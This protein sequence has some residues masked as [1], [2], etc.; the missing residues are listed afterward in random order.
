MS[1]WRRVAWS[2]GASAVT[3]PAMRRRPI[4][5][6][7]AQPVNGSAIAA[8]FG[9]AAAGLAHAGLD[10]RPDT[11]RGVLHVAA[12]GLQ[13]AVESARGGLRLLLGERLHHGH[14][15]EPG[16]ESQHARLVLEGAE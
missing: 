5:S 2:S 6:T 7:M 15:V 16:E 3:Y 10:D 1:T 13:G 12:C 8:A 14:R 4:S 9:R 11:F